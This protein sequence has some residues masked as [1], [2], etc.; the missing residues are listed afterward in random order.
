MPLDT[1][2]KE[3]LMIFFMTYNSYLVD[4]KFK[5]KFDK[6]KVSLYSK[7]EGVLISSNQLL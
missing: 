5:S 2:F 4:Q 7:T 6:K 3:F 1:H